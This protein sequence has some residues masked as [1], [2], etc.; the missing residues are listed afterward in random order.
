MNS[1]P[2][3]LSGPESEHVS[4]DGGLREHARNRR[5]R[6]V[7]Q[8]A[9]PAPAPRGACL[10]PR[11]GPRA[12]YISRQNTSIFARC[13][14]PQRARLASVS[15]KGC[16]RRGVAVW[17]GVARCGAAGAW[18]RCRR[19]VVRPRAAGGAGAAR[20]GRQLLGV[21]RAARVALLSLGASLQR[22]ARELA[23][24]FATG[25]V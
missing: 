9:G 12:R 10:L 14:R 20:P 8:R 4:A 23:T 13:V 3:R 22:C 7:T 17:R 15:R 25:Q 16:R 18:C 24:R 19:C 11:G 2:R 21:R 5:D 1:G 6:C